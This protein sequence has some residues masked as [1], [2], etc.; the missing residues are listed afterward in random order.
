M[1]SSV[2][3]GHVSRPRKSVTDP[4]APATPRYDPAQRSF[5]ARLAAIQELSETGGAAATDALLAAMGDEDPL[6]REEVVQALAAI[7]E[8]TVLLALQSALRDPSADVREAAINAFADI[9]GNGSASAL[10]IALSDPA[11]SLRSDTVDAPGEIG[12]YRARQTVRQALGDG[13][14]AV[15]EAAAETLAEFEAER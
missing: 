10:S 14:T 15:S 12:G 6:V 4:A 9:G 7:P 13:D 3:I 2:P 1:I 8:P 5:G 11:R